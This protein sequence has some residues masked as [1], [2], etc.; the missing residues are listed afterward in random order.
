MAMKFPKQLPQKVSSEKL[1]TS[2]NF[3]LIKEAQVTKD[4]TLDIFETY[5]PIWNSFNIKDRQR[6]NTYLVGRNLLVDAN[7][8][9]IEIQP[10][11]WI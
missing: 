11:A 10:L 4:L 7:Q 1:V 2:I 3:E 9:T 6:F 8:G 5:K